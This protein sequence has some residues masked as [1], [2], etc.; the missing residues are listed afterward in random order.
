MTDISIIGTGCLIV[1][2]V[3]A[4]GVVIRLRGRIAELEIYSEIDDLTIAA[5]RKSLSSLR[6]AEAKTHAQRIA[7]AKKGRAT[8]TAR[9]LAK[10]AAANV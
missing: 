5:L 1:A 10:K 7:A 9:A 8:Q 3:I 6:E 2:L 4:A